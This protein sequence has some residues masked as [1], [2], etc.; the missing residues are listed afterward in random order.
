MAPSCALPQSTLQR[1]SRSK[2]GTSRRR[3]PWTHAPAAQT[4]HLRC[5]RASSP[6][7]ARPPARRV[8]SVAAAERNQSTPCGWVQRAAPQRAVAPV[9]EQRKGLL[10]V[11]TPLALW[12]ATTH[13][14]PCG[15][16]YPCA[17][18]HHTNFRRSPPRMPAPL[19]RHPAS[20]A[21]CIDT[22]CIRRCQQLHDPTAVAGGHASSRKRPRWDW[23]R[24]RR[25]RGK[26]KR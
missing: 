11:P 4:P 25:R 8:H 23:A 16:H 20:R 13:R 2:F 3:R 9:S 12:Y 19:L 6:L 1:C 24:G 18:T 22:M 14:T 10:P 21:A 26:A 15:C 7:G 5:T 17:Q